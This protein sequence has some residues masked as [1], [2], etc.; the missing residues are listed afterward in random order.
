MRVP[1]VAMGFILVGGTGPS[2]N[3]ATLDLV[4]RDLFPT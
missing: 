3:N 1:T 2:T 4:K